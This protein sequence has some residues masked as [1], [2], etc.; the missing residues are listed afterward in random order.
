MI[1]KLI[2]YCWF[3]GK[4]LPSLASKCI[5][6]WEKHLPDYQLILWNEENFDIDTVPYVK[7]AY[8]SG[9]YAFVT[10][11]IRLYA[12]YHYGGIYMDTDVEVIKNMDNL[13]HLPGFSGFESD[14]DVPTGIM[15]CEK[16]NEWA[17]EQLDFYENKHFLKIDRTLDL[18]SNVE[19][20]S[21]SMA[22][23]GFRLDNKYQVYKN[24]MHFFPK[25]YFCPKSRTGIINI[26]ANTYCIHHFAASWLPPHLKL[27]NFFFRK[28]LGAEITDILVRTK[29]KLINYSR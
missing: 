14:K 3:G 18:T 26:T 2:H 1:P 8:A 15:A 27:K 6:S 9:K 7:E 12:L 28:L 10:D 24:C 25:D 23:K 29:R 11:Y 13:L 16:Y 5:N 17:K 21:R 22:A 20:I 4:S 19:I